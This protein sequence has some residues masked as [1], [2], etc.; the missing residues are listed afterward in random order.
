RVSMMLSAERRVSF[1]LPAAGRRPGTADG[2]FIGS[3]S[4]FANKRL[5]PNDGIPPAG[6]SSPPEADRRVRSHRRRLF[7]L[8]G[9]EAALDCIADQLRE[10]PERELIHDVGPVFFHRLR[11]DPQLFRDLFVL[12]ALRDKLH[13]LSFPPGQIQTGHRPFVL[14][15]LLALH[16]EPPPLTVWGKSPIS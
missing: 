9:G 3:P 8:D 13:D 10:V 1:V 15:A 16:P 4:L 11:L 7:N 5:N 12:V 6:P 2:S 14:R